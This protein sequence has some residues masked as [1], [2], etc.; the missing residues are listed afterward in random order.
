MKE[1][2]SILQKMERLSLQ[3]LATMMRFINWQGEKE[4]KW[5]GWNADRTQQNKLISLFLLGFAVASPNLL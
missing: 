5:V 2:C 4:L 3:I 1:F